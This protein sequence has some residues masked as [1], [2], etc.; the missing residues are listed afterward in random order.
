MA[1]SWHF[2]SF[3]DA[4]IATPGFQPQLQFSVWQFE[5]IPPLLINKWRQHWEEINVVPYNAT[6]SNVLWFF[7]CAQNILFRLLI[8]GH[9]AGYCILLITAAHLIIIRYY[10]MWFLYDQVQNGTFSCLHIL[11]AIANYTF[12]RASWALCVTETAQRKL[13]SQGSSPSC[14]SSP[15]CWLSSAVALFWSWG[16]CLWLAKPFSPHHGAGHRAI[17][18]FSFCQDS[19]MLHCACMVIY[20]R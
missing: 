18:K 12:T 6:G 7:T 2:L 14:T 20:S 15:K 1:Y 19:E 4:E 8:S 16:I 11:S 10:M 17:C 9:P 13:C 5:K 3:S